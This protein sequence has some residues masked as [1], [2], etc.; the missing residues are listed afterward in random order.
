MLILILL[1]LFFTVSNYL[2]THQG[3]CC[4]RLATFVGS[5]ANLSGQKTSVYY[6]QEDRDMRKLFHFTIAIKGRWHK[7]YRQYSSAQYAPLCQLDED[8]GQGSQVAPS[9]H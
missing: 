1:F 3:S 6:P 7:C 9:N 5:L 2:G 4:R 8:P